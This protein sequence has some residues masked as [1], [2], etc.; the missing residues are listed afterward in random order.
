VHTNARRVQAAFAAAGVPIEVVEFD[1]STRTAAEAAAAIGTSVAQIA[2]S[3]VFLA[4]EQPLLV[5]TSGANRVSTEKLAALVGVPVRRA[6]ADAVRRATGFPVG[7]VPPLGHAA[8]LRIL[9]DRDLLA[10]EEIWAAAGTPNSVFRIAPAALV[11][12]TGGEPADVREEPG[13]A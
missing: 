8:P 9:L 3:L 13:A 6:D 10:F 4:G 11:R 12:V 2:K 7:G 5:I 1:E